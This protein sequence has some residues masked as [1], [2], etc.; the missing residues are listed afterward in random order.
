MSH[1][2][3]IDSNNIVLRVIV[4]DDNEPDEGYRW[5]VENLGGRWIKTSYN[6]RY[7]EHLLGG[8]PLRGNYAGEGMIYD[9]SLDAFIDPAP[10]PSWILNTEKYKWE[11]PVEPPSEGPGWVWDESSLDWMPSSITSE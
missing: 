6:T 8:T 4:G 10:Y 11:P 5:I 7:G 3:E 9:E 1:W 2:A